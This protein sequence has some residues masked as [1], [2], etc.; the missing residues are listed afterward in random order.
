MGTQFWFWIFLLVTLFWDTLFVYDKAT[1]AE[2]DND[3][4]VMIPKFCFFGNF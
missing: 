1:V 3:K 2:D 4:L